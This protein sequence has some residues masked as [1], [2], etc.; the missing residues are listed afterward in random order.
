MAYKLEEDEDNNILAYGI[1]VVYTLEGSKMM[2]LSLVSI[3]KILYLYTEVLV[4]FFYTWL[5]KK[6]TQL[7]NRMKKHFETKEIS[8]E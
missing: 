7:E 2:F 4:I 1:L 6:K 3:V 8:N 5:V